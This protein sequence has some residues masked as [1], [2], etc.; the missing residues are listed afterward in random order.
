MRMARLAPSRRTG[1]EEVSDEERAVGKDKG[2]IS[3]SKTVSGSFVK[4]EARL[5]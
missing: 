5:S 3:I 1:P 2:R 4:M